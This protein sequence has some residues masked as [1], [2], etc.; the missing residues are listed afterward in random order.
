MNPADTDHPSVTNPDSL[1]RSE[2]KTAVSDYH[3]GERVTSLRE[4]CK[5]YQPFGRFA[6]VFPTDATLLSAITSGNSPL[7]MA[8]PVLG[9]KP[10]LVST[11]NHPGLIG[12]LMPMYRLMRG[13]L[14]FKIKVSNP[15]K[16]TPSFRGYVGFLPGPIRLA[17]A[18]VLQSLAVS[19][20]N[21]SETNGTC[22]PVAYFSQD[23][24]CEF[25]VPF[26]NHYATAFNHNSFDVGTP[27]SLRSEYSDYQLVVFLYADGIAAT[28]RYDVTISYAF[29]DETH[30]GVF[31]GVPPTRRLANVYP[32]YL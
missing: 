2:A 16:D 21:R 1:A 32:N 9:E 18:N 8:I 3:F 17:T 4:M 6:Q 24:V 22:P 14:T 10:N 27:L 30:F 26:V 7:V 12:T 5:R 15:S 28:S 23:Q 19:G 20:I 29:A 11:T 25:M 13:P 31:L